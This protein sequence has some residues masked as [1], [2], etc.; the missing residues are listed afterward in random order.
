MA[1]ALIVTIATVAVVVGALAGASESRASVGRVFVLALPLFAVAGATIMPGGVVWWSAL[2]M[3]IVTLVGVVLAGPIG[4]S[5]DA[6]SQQRPAL[7]VAVMAG[8]SLVAVVLAAVVVRWLAPIIGSFTNLSALAVSI[9]VLSAAV[10]ATVFG[11]GRFGLARTALVT[12]AVTAVLLLVAG[13]AVGAPGRALD[14]VVPVEGPTTAGLVLGLLATVL[15]GAVHPG[16][17]ALAKE[18]GTLVRG[19]I[20]TAVVGLAGLWGLIFLA[21]GSLN[22]PSNALV[23]VTGYIAF[24]PSLVGAVLAGLVA[25][26]LTIIAAATIEAVLQP[27][28]GH[29]G[30]R[31]IGWMS[32]HW[33]A[34]F[35][36]GLG[37]YLLSVS[38]VSGGWLLGT[39]GFAA[40]AVLVASWRIGSGKESPSD[41]GVEVVGTN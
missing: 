25:L 41:A 29:D 34:V 21:G 14:P 30:M 27:W 31:P 26:V 40:V 8:R 7:S 13:I 15:A 6:V 3:A 33:V 28:H 18:S 11:G 1:A 35:A 16:L 4:R 32:H 19:G 38:S 36:A 20:V 17:S 37:V 39:L 2:L 9:V 24:A 23:T 5:L 22:F 12:S 10:A